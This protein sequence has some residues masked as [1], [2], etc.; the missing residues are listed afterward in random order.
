M[1]YWYRRNIVAQRNVSRLNEQEIEKKLAKYYAK[2]QKEIIGQFVET[3]NKVL[4]SITDG[5]TPTPAD[6]YKLDTY[7]QGQ[8]QLRN[9]LKELGNKEAELLSAAFIKQYSDIYQAIAIPGAEAFNTLDLNMAAQVIES[10]WAADGKAW[11]ERV[12]D[13]VAQL[14][15]TLEDEL[16][17]CV[18][19]GKKT[20][21]LKNILQERFGVSYSR[22][23]TLVRTEMAHI[24]TTAAQ[25]RYED[26]GVSEVEIWADKDERRCEHCGELHMKR[27]PIGGKIPIPAHPNCRCNI[28]PVVEI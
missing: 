13:N 9:I 24:T 26:A 22:A 3:Y 28:L 5:R 11:S 23:N 14:A 18:I 7:W 25:K 15:Q 16:I 10:I 4:L 6:L 19:S 27:F 8:V 20:T 17:H 2:A 12:W 21:E 1:D